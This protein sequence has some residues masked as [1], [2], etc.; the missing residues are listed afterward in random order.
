[1]ENSLQPIFSHAEPVF[2]VVDVEA[3]IAYWQTVLGFTGK[4]TWGEPPTLGSVSWQTIFIQF[5]RNP[6]LAASS[7]GNN[8]WIRLQRIEALYNLHKKNNAEI[9]AP[10]EQK[11]YGLAQYTVREINGYYLHFA[12]LLEEREKS[13]T[14]LPDTVRIT[15]G[16]PAAAEYLDFLMGMDDGHDKPGDDEIQKRLDNTLYTAVAEDTLTGKII[17]CAFLAGD[18]V[19]FYYVKDVAV[20]PQWRGKQVGTALMRELDNWLEKYGANNALVGLFARDTLEPFYQQ[21]G[22]GRG[23]AMLKYIHRD[24]KN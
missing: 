6:T 5:I 12:G 1:M 2:A 11:E 10:L 16:L 7:K 4:W 17:G 14:M 23:F 9:V 20:H 13:E 8:V 3:T 18:G 19:S 15:G 24:E 21:F 22:F